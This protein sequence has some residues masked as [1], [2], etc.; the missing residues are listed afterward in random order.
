M[1]V[2]PKVHGGFCLCDCFINSFNLSAF[3]LC[4][5]PN[6]QS[7]HEME[8]H[9]FICEVENLK[10]EG[11]ELLYVHPYAIDLFQLPELA[12]HLIDDILREFIVR[13]YN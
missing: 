8:L 1:L 13:W 9:I 10:C 4:L 2:M 11:S 3:Q 6:L 12:L 7:I 5:D